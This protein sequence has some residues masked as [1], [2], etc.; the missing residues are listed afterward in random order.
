MQWR[1]L[2]RLRHIFI[3]WSLPISRWRAATD[4][5]IGHAIFNRSRSKDESSQEEQCYQIEF[6]ESPAGGQSQPTVQT[7]GHNANNLA[8]GT[9]RVALLLS[10]LACVCVGTGSTVLRGRDR[11]AAANAD[12]E[13]SL[14]DD[15]NANRELEAMPP[16]AEIHNIFMRGG[17]ENNNSEHDESESSS[18][19]DDDN[20]TNSFYDNKSDILLNKGLGFLWHLWY[21]EGI[22]YEARGTDFCVMCKGK[23]GCEKGDEVVTS[24]CN[25]NDANMRWEYIKIKDGVGLMKTRTRNLC[26]EMNEKK[27]Y[28][29]QTCERKEERQMF[30]GLSYKSK[31]KLHPYK[32]RFADKEQCISMLHR[33][34]AKDEHDGEEIIDQPCY[35]PERTETVY[36]VADFRDEVKEKIGKKDYDCS[37]KNKCKECEGNCSSDNECKGDLFCYKR[38]GEKWRE[39][40]KD[41]DNPNGWAEIP[42]CQGMGKYGRNYCSIE[43]YESPYSDEQ[44]EEILGQNDY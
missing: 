29:L 6:A 17:G 4:L 9:M 40:L 2:L 34:L 13:D 27:E 18:S 30:Q 28:R 43:K 14:H 23:S 1:L 38:S 10:T 3:C 39:S 8:P 35:K 12:A 20:N 41:G 24:H 33:P 11:S 42:G 25:P 31:F 37:K 32:R 15:A 22:K 7:L 19:D 26:L 5:Q 36:W 44:I 16:Y 21:K